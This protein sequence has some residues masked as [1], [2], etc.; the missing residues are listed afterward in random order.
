MT[1]T[2]YKNNGNDVLNVP[3]EQGLEKKLSIELDTFHGFTEE[4]VKI[5]ET[6]SG[7]ADRGSGNILIGIGAVLAISSIFLVVFPAV[8][9][10]PE[11]INSLVLLAGILFIAGAIARLYVYRDISRTNRDIREFNQ[12][13]IEKSMNN[14]SEIRK[15]IMDDESETRRF[16]EQM[17]RDSNPPTPKP[18]AG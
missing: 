13:M 14:S 12:K 11:E 10:E 2:T 5:I 1:N 9:V 16:N 4:S 17:R 6:V 3:Q 8:S 15:Q 18:N 7:L